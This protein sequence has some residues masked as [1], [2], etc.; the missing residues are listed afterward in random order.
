MFV[1]EPRLGP[2]MVQAFT[3]A[4]ILLALRTFNYYEKKTK[5]SPMMTVKSFP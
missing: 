3:G 2:A 4:H 5:L 1:N